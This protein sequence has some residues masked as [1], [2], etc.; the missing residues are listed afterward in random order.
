MALS[1][2]YPISHVARYVLRNAVGVYVLSR[3]GRTAAYVGRSDSDLQGRL[4]QSARQGRYTHFWFDDE[5]SPMQAYKHECE[6]YHT[7][8]PPDNGVH[9]AVPPGTNWRCPILGCLWS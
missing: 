8:N 2:P 6:L 9:P 7:Y 3:D 5:T 1:G 4:L